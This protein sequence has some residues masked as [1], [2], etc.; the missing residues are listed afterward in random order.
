MSRPQFKLRTMLRLT[1]L[2][3]AF[4]AARTTGNRRAT[5][6]ITWERKRIK[7]ERA[8]LADR[9]QK[10]RELEEHIHALEKQER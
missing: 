1:A 3:A 8:S 6:V 2:V 4:F 5:S 10:I 9:E 7:K